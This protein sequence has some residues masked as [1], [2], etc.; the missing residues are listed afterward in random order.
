MAQHANG[1][2][3]R[4]RELQGL[5]QSEYPGWRVVVESV[6]TGGFDGFLIWASRPGNGKRSVIY[7]LARNELPTSTHAVADV[8]A[9]VRNAIAAVFPVVEP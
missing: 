2:T 1:T 4:R 7:E 9:A 3:D 6:A 5:L 8:A